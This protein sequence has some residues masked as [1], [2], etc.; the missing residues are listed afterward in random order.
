ML[1]QAPKGTQDTLPQ[2]SYR[3]QSIEKS[4]RDICALAGYREIR[5]PV[6][7]HTELFQRGVGDTT[8]VVQKEMYTFNDKGNRSITLKPE[9]TAGAV[10][11]FIEAHLFA[12]ALPC[13]MFYV[14]CPCF[15]YEKPQSGRMRQ[16]H[17]NGVEVFGAKDASVDAE[18]IALALKILKANR[19]EGLRLN[20]NSIGCPECRKAYLEKLRAYLE[21]KLP[22]LCQTCRDRFQRNPLRI[23]D[24]KEDADK[25]ADAPAMLDNL[26]PECSAHFEKLKAYLAAMDIEYAVDPR[27]VRGL[28][29][30]TKTVFE[31]ITETPNG[32]LTVCGGG[33][34]DGLVEELGGPATPG[35]GFG[36]G[37]ERMIM[38]Q[39]MRGVAPEAPE[40]LDAFVVTMGDEARMAGVKLVSALREQGIKA[41]IDHAARSMKAQF[42]FANKIGVRNVVVIAGDELEKGVVKLRDMENSSETEV[43]GDEIV[44]LL[45]KTLPASR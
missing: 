8:D 41:D 31:I 4:V 7:E 45:T 29:Y 23:L 34:Y 42:K 33:R 12:D 3:W 28:D 11:A 14:S 9:G 25:L 16:F 5:T 38:V 1:T 10:R 18:I 30:Y 6:F 17:Q 37:V 35:I 24:C 2:D 13:K 15:R 19:I 43:P 27:I 36:M 20:V 26:C 39:D 32:D 40:L 21:P 44:R 22:G